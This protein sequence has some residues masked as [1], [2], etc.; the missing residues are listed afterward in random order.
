MTTINLL[1]VA[2]R[3]KTD[4]LY[5]FLEECGAN[6][7]PF[8]DLVP[9]FEFIKIEN[10]SVLKSRFEDGMIIR[11]AVTE[12]K[13]KVFNLFWKNTDRDVK[14]R[15]VDLFRNRRGSAGLMWYKPIDEID[16]IK[17]RF[18]AD[19]LITTQLQYGNY[20]IQLSLAQAL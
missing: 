14:D 6:D 16:Y 5:E 20:Q 10:Y 12:A 11:R 2:E 8:F 13:K 3:V 19:S 1:A 15:L 17:V 18:V 7:Y 4:G 9:E